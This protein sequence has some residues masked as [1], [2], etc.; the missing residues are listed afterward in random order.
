MRS[1]LES[2]AEGYSVKVVDLPSAT[3]KV[4]TCF[5]SFRAS[6][7]EVVA[8]A[9]RTLTFISYRKRAE[10]TV[11]TPYGVNKMLKERCDVF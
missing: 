3:Q 2:S 6:G 9:A 11:S 5:E 10:I 1:S 7:G 4:Q 8:G